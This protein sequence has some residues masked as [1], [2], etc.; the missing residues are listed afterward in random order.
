[1][2]RILLRGTHLTARDFRAAVNLLYAIRRRTGDVPTQDGHVSFKLPPDSTMRTNA[3]L[4]VAPSTASDAA[5]IDAARLQEAEQREVAGI[6]S[7]ALTIG[8][9]AVSSPR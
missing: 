3:R 5:T 1:M 7:E 4:S 9:R 8:L 6:G 2:T